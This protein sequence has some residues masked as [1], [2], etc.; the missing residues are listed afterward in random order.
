MPLSAE[1]TFFMGP[2]L[3]DEDNRFEVVFT[4]KLYSVDGMK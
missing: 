3:T 1:E 2:C 4:A